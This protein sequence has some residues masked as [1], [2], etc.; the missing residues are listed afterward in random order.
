MSTLL[1]DASPVE[2][3]EGHGSVSGQK[4]IR[5]IRLHSSRVTLH[6]RLVLAF[7]KVSVPLKHRQTPSVF[8]SNYSQDDEEEETLL[9]LSF[10]TTA[11]C[12]LCCNRSTVVGSASLSLFS[13]VR[14]LEPNTWN[15]ASVT[16][17]S[18]ST[19]VCQ[20][21]PLTH[22]LELLDLSPGLRASRIQLE[23][24]LIIWT[25]SRREDTKWVLWSQTEFFIHF[26]LFNL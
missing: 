25:S 15:E 11:S 5:P 6:R 16:D 21:G 19:R 7:F 12:F 14:A 20:T 26:F 1:R 22:L 18:R 2:F 23:N 10:C 13:G 4:R 9:T 24:H 17:R 3:E 8:R